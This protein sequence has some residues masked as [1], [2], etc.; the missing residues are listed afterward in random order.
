[1]RELSPNAERDA[2]L[3]G[4]MKTNGWSRRMLGTQLA[5]WAELRHDTLLYAKQSFTAMALCEYPDAYVKPYPSFFQ[6]LSRLAKKGAWPVGNRNFGGS[7]KLILDY[8]TRFGEVAEMLGE[9]A[10]LE[11]E[12]KPLRSEHIDFMNHAVSV[13]GK[14]GGCTI[15]YEPGGWYADLHYDR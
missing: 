7:K 2:A 15:I 12:K 5:S 14:H 8:F 13:D 6:A 10:E 4:V 1:V 11:R 3:P 9:M